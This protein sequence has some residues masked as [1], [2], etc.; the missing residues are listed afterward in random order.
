MS[1]VAFSMSQDFLM[2]KGKV[3]KLEAFVNSNDDIPCEFCFLRFSFVTS[4]ENVLF[5]RREL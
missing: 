1:A 4:R 3:R 2:F 5:F